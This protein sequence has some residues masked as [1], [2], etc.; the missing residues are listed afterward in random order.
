MTIQ[1]KNAGI[2]LSSTGTTSV[3]TAPDNA[4]ILIKQIQ[5]DNTS[6][7]PVN[8]SVQVTDTSATASFR[9]SGNPIPASTT[10]D[11]ITQ[12]LVLEESD[13]LKMTAGTAGELQGII[14]YAQ[15]DRSQENG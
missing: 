5:I 1:Y 4:R 8:L 14:S 15:I 12:T 9:I 10:K 7:N 13:I 2:N 11:L 6:V 3:L